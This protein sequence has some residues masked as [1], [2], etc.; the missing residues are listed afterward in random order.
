MKNQIF[1]E[2]TKKLRVNLHDIIL[3][4]KVLTH[5]LPIGQAES[6]LATR[7]LQECRHWLG[8]VLRALGDETPYPNADIPANP[9]IDPQADIK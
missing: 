5:D 4:L 8:E 2:R 3:E 6:V 7:K 1:I 9:I